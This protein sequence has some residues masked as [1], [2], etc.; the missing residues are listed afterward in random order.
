MQS[1]T[2][3]Q[4]KLLVE[5]NPDLPTVALDLDGTL[6]HT[7]LD[8]AEAAAAKRSGLKTFGLEQPRKGTVVVRPGL[9]KLVS[10]MLGYNVVLFS[11][12]ASGYVEAVLTQ[13]VKEIPIL[14]RT[15]CKI[16]SRSDLVMYSESCSLLPCKT[17][18][19]MQGVNY[20]KDL[21][22]ARLDGN[23]E[24]VLLVDDYEY[25][26]QV[27][28]HMKDADFKSKYNFTMNAV[29]VPKFTA[30][31]PEAPNDTVFAQVGDV[32]QEIVGFYDTIAALNDHPG[33]TL[34]KQL[35]CSGLQECAI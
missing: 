22:K 18:R 32:L 12:G 21:R 23:T 26:Y 15:F 34:L 8:P 25:A 5:E 24:K 17:M 1:V 33:L 27:L 10:S 2:K 19:D 31:D 6:I 4:S 7:L 30:T 28:P 29:P 11:A 20:V 35:S 13:L 16:L 9:E 3:S 14:Q